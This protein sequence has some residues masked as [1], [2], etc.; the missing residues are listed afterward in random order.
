MP[1]LQSEKKVRRVDSHKD[2][3]DYFLEEISPAML[4]PAWNES[5]ECRL[6]LVDKAKMRARQ[7]WSDEN[8]PR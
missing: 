1:N 3:F 8:M 4:L 7:R 2:I 6:Y 5:K